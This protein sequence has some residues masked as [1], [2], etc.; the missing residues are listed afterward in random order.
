MPY[1]DLTLEEHDLLKVK[2]RLRSCGVSLMPRVEERDRVRC[3]TM[4]ACR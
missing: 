4:A 1:C 2:T 3:Q